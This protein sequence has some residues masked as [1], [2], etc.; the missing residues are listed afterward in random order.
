M[1]MAPMF[2]NNRKEIEFKV[3]T[4]N[5]EGH[6]VV[7]SA[8]NRAVAISLL[9]EEL[10]PPQPIE[11]SDLIPLATYTRTVRVLK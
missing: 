8:E 9:E 2:N 10:D 11:Y 5:K 4:F 1:S 3:W 6:R 7:V